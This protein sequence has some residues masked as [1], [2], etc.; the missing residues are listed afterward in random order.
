LKQWC[1]WRKKVTF[2]MNIVKYSIPFIGS[3]TFFVFI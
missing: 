2:I 1:S 3:A